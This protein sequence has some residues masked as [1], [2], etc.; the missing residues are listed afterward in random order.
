MDT[1]KIQLTLEINHISPISCKDNDQKQVVHSNSD[2][3][4]MMTNDNVDEV[5]KDLFES[6]LSK[7]LIALETVIKGSNFIFDCVNFLYCKC[8]KINLSRVGSYIN[9]FNWIKIKKQ[10]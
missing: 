5:I 3:I 7:Y 9:S 2:N 6:L 8:Y 1:W 4:E 10:Q